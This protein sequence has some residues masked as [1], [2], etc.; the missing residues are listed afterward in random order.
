VPVLDTSI[1]RRREEIVSEMLGRLIAAIPDV[2]TGDDGVIRIVFEIEAG[3]LE[4]LYLSSQLLLQ[5]MFITTASNQ[6][7]QRHGDQYGLPMAQGTRSTGQLEFS[8]DDGT[9][10]PLGTLAAYDPGGGIDPVYFQTMADLQLPTPG[11]P[12]AP[13]AAGNN[14][15]DSYEYVVTFVTDSGETLPGLESELIRDNATVSLTQISVGG[16]G[17]T[18]RR[19]YRD[20][21]GSGQYHLVAQ[22]PNNTATT[23]SDNISDATVEAGPLAPTV[24]TA[25]RGVVAA[26]SQDVGVE[27]NVAARTI[28]IISSGPATLT[29]VT[30]P[31]PFT[32]ASDP[33]D[34]DE[35][36]RRL[37]NF[38]QNPETGSAVDIQSWAES[39]P[40]VESA[41]IFENTPSP[42]SVTVRIS[43]DGGTIPSAELIAQTQATLNDR[44]YAN[45]TVV[46]TSFT[47][48]TTNVTVDVTPLLG[49]TLSEVTPSV[50]NA[51][52]RYINNLAVGET[53]RI[54]GIIDAVFGL[55]GIA[56]VVVTNPT[57]NQT[58]NPAEKRVAG[59]ITVV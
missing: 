38:I 52:T 16:P 36:R 59:T 10:V 22:I 4:S 11:I 44:D 21:N 58:T 50:Q 24:D 34:S 7:L 1:Y 41:T 43:G 35:Y 8:G 25:H 6:A 27:G 37:L 20:R 45:I 54:A 15:G 2:Y 49:N 19:I 32:G 30:N 28:T 13:V 56:D 33:E 26:S 18:A 48:V 14:N 5:D 39:V 12:D 55:S 9:F 29:D 57:S 42:G 53:L 3:Q 23:F 46:V 40:G 17:T 47:S 51:V 31:S